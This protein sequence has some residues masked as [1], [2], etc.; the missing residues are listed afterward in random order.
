MLS[1]K[2]K[3]QNKNLRFF[4]VRSRMIFA[5]KRKQCTFIV[6]HPNKSSSLS[7]LCKGKWVCSLTF[8]VSRKIATSLVKCSFSE[9]NA[10]ICLWLPRADSRL[11]NRSS[12][13][14]WRTII[15]CF[16]GK[17]INFLVINILRTTTENFKW[18]RERNRSAVGIYIFNLKIHSTFIRSS[19]LTNFADP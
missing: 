16:W 5:H 11:R 2:Q 3:K 13:S 6:L 8:I 14:S 7:Y 18:I 4:L 15:A 9:I 19:L 10:S 12:S 1:V 17:K